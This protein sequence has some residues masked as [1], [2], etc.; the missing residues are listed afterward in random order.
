MR[1]F[2]VGPGSIGKLTQNHKSRAMSPLACTSGWILR[3]QVICKKGEIGNHYGQSCHHLTGGGQAPS[4]GLMGSKIQ[5]QGTTSYSDK[6]HRNKQS[7]RASWQS[8][9]KLE[10]TPQYHMSLCDIV[11][12]YTPKAP[13]L[14]LRFLCKGATHQSRYCGISHP[15]AWGRNIIWIFILMN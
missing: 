9:Y 5:E 1:T 6:N 15:S 2:H 13:A 11:P 8:G 14:T 12:L 10:L 3:L 7:P 4:L